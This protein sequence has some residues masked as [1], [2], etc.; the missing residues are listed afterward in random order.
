MISFFW[1]SSTRME[2]KIS[3]VIPTL[4]R[5]PDLKKLL[6]KFETEPFPRSNFEVIVVDD[7]SCDGTQEFM[8]LLTTPFSLTPIIHEQNRGSASSRKE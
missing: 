1:Y 3:V 5:L 7:G 4:N 8:K 6:R 2:N